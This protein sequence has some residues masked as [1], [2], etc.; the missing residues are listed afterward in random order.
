MHAENPSLPPAAI[1]EI[2]SYVARELMTLG[3]KT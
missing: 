2:E 3:A 1:L